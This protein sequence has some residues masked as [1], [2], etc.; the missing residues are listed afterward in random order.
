MQQ[1]SHSSLLSNLDGDLALLSRIPLH[2]ALKSSSWRTLEDVSPVTRLREWGE[3]CKR[4]HLH[5][6]EKAGELDA[7]MLGLKR[8]VEGLLVQVSPRFYKSHILIQIY[9]D[10][11]VTLLFGCCCHRT[12]MFPCLYLYSYKTFPSV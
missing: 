10:R 6:S 7:I 11:L 3:H 9:S 8:D 2:A 12:S 5:F 4:S 1:K